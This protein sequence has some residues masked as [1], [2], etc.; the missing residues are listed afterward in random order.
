MFSVVLNF[1]VPAQVKVGAVEYV[2]DLTEGQLIAGFFRSQGQDASLLR[3]EQELLEIMEQNPRALG[4]VFSGGPEDPKA[5]IYRQGYEPDP[6]ILALRAVVARV[7]SD[8]GGLGM[9]EAHENIFLRPES[10]K[11][12]FNKSLVPLVLATEMVFLGFL[13]VAVMMFQGKAEGGVRAF[14]VSPSTTLTYVGS[15]VAANVIM[16]VVYGLLV[17]VFTIGLHP[18][19]PRVMLVVA[20][21]RAVM[22]SLGLV[23]GTF[24]GGISDFIYPAILMM[25]AMGLP[26]RSYFFPSFRPAW[27]PLTPSYQLMFTAREL[28]FP[29]GK[30]GFCLPLALTLA[31]QA[32]LAFGLAWFAVDRRLMKEGR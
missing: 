30:V 10:V 3:S 32:A 14:R 5:T 19:L 16:A 4:I 9:P 21:T 25:L 8:A 28:L 12:P 13:F 29:T 15:K 24:F 18:N 22:T 27:F 2:V 17:L 11:P 20:A 26:V 1:A 23:V 7:W 6:A 31:A